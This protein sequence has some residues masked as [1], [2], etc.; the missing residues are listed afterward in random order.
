M[1]DI[2]FKSVF[3]HTSSEA[4]LE[5]IEDV[6]SQQSGSFTNL[7]D[8]GTVHIQTA[9]TNA[10][11]EFENVPKPREIQDILSDLLELAH[12]GEI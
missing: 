9:G 6:T 10:F 3:F 11:I 4:R 5:K 1:I 7:L 2:D 8:I 12:K